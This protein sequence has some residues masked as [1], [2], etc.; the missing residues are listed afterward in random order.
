M[1]SS[2]LLSSSYNL[3][4]YIMEKHEF[5]DGTLPI[6]VETYVRQKLTP[7]EVLQIIDRE[8]LDEIEP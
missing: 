3:I 8:K 7:R 1:V 5:E 2:V 6:H 4:Q